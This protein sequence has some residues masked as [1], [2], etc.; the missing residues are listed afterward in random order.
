MVAS[1]KQEQLDDDRKK[2]YCAKQFDMSDE[3]KKAGQP[4]SQSASQP[5]GAAAIVLV[6]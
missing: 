2:E 1:L 6:W 5:M 3:K 4:A